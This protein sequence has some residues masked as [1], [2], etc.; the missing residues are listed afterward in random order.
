MERSLVLF[1]DQCLDGLVAAWFAFRRFG[2]TA[3]YLAVRYKQP[4]PD[5]TD[6]VVY[7]LDFCYSPEETAVIADEAARVVIIDHHASAIEE[8]RARWKERADVQAL[9][10]V[11]AS[12]AALTARYF[13]VAAKFWIPD[14]VSDRDLWRFELPHSR[15]IN[16]MFAANCLG[17]APLDAFSVLEELRG[18]S[19]HDAVIQGVGA[20]KQIE[21]YVRQMV[22]EVRWQTFLGYSDI[23]VIN[24]PKPFNS[25]VLHA[26]AKRAQFAVAW[27]VESNSAVFSLRSEG[28]NVRELC[29]R[30]GGGG[31]DPAAGFTLP[32][33][34]QELW[35][36][37]GCL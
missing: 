25:E 15:E 4:H 3:D 23:P 11:T 24:A 27:R 26:L 34:S 28:F 35:R 20:Q 6:R 19:M 16:A 14:Y 1:H 13:D 36:V 10:D 8:F 2:E 5:C 32:F 12:G 33:P 29:E 31:H 22:P 21:A 7:I 18:L 37:L 30:F 9:F 17:R